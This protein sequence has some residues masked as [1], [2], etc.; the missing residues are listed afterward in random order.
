MQT[1]PIIDENILTTLL[2]DQISGNDLDVSS[3]NDTCQKGRISKIPTNISNIKK[4][5]TEF[6]NQVVVPQDKQPPQ[7]RRIFKII[8]IG[9]SNVG[10]YINLVLFS[11]I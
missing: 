11:H 8:V 10:K 9:D 6:E 7:Q 3:S 2:V 5:N 1:V 4:T